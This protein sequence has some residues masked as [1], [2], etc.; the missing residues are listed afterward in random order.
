MELFRDTDRQSGRTTGKSDDQHD[1][2]V[3][4][5]V[6]G[7]LTE[8]H[9]LDLPRIVGQP[10]TR[11]EQKDSSLAVRGVQLVSLMGHQHEVDLTVRAKNRWRHAGHYIAFRRTLAGLHD[12][13]PVIVQH[14]RQR[15]RMQ[16][17][18]ALIV[19]ADARSIER[20]ANGYAGESAACGWPRR[21]SDY[22]APARN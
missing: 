14:H 6:L 17:V 1:S 15:T 21:G 22:G 8:P 5:D 3:R 12:P 9:A 2:S 10:V 11:R 19:R 13:A 16:H 7:S 18:C 4:I 20:V